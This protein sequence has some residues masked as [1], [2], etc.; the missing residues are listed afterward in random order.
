MVLTAEHDVLRDEGE[1]YAERLRAAGVPVEFSDSPA[2][3][4]ASSGR[5]GQRAVQ[6]KRRLAGSTCST[7]RRSTDEP[8][9]DRGQHRD[10]IDVVIGGLR[11]PVHAAPPARSA[12]TVASTR[13]GDGVGGTW[14]WNRYPGARCDFEILDYSYSFSRRAGA[15]VGVDRASTRRSRRS[16]A[17]STTSPTASTCAATSS[18]TRGSRPAYDDERQRW[19]VETDHGRRCRRVPDH[20]DRLPVGGQSPTI[21]GSTTFQGEWYHTGRWPHEGVDFAGKRVGVIGTGSTGI[22]S[23]P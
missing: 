23:I 2:R 19:D 4:T 7:G 20:G 1:A 5:D 9:A 8:G 10:P 6:G 3:C 11:R 22:Q 15:G 14:Y 18:S 16:C 13:P 17:T 21:P 12:L